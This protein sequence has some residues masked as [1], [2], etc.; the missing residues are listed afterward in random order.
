MVC[1][2]LPNAPRRVMFR[3]MK[4]VKWKL[5]ILFGVVLAALLS[6]VAWLW[7][8]N[9]RLE[10]E[11]LGTIDLPGVALESSELIESFVYSCRNDWFP[12]VLRFERRRMLSGMPDIQFPYDFSMKS[13]VPGTDSP[14]SRFQFLCAAVDGPLAGAYRFLCLFDDARPGAQPV[15]AVRWKNGFPDIVLRFPAPGTITVVRADPD[16]D[17]DPERNVAAGENVRDFLGGVEQLRQKAAAGYDAILVCV[18]KKAV[19]SIT[20][21]SLEFDG[22]EVVELVN[23]RDGSTTRFDCRR[24]RVDLA[25]ACPVEFSTESTTGNLRSSHFSGRSEAAV[26]DLLETV[27][28]TSSPSDLAGRTLAL[29][30][31]VETY[32]R[33]L[34]RERGF[35]G[36]FG[37]GQSL[38]LWCDRASGMPVK[39]AGA[40]RGVP[41]EVELVEWRSMVLERQGVETGED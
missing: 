3:I 32:N 16:G 10:R 25:Y 2:L 34:D 7:L 11:S 29:P 27:A 38:T 5:A 18:I 21:I 30:V 31:S 17:L 39:I 40:V 6:G 9:K 35:E 19:T 20:A 22:A 41:V 4:S 13:W 1:P 8:Q 23:G 37:L 15:A 12:F 33:L 24:Y 36:P 14:Q 26:A 28:G